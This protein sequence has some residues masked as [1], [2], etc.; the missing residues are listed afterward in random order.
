MSSQ[1]CLKLHLDSD[2][3]RVRVPVDKCQKVDDICNYVEMAWPALSEASYRL[4]Y[5]DDMD[6]ACILSQISLPD[7]LA[8]AEES[9]V[10][11]M[12][13]FVDI[14]DEED[15]VVVDDPLSRMVDELI[16]G[17]LI[18][19]YDVGQELVRVLQDAGQD[20]DKVTQELA[21]SRSKKSG[22]RTTTKK[23]APKSPSV[24]A[25]PKLQPQSSLKIEREVSD[26]NEAM[27]T[28]VD[29]LSDLGFVDSKKAARDLMNN[30]VSS[31]DDLNKVADNIKRRVED[32]QREDAYSKA[33]EC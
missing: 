16:D 2:I 19:S 15:V 22:S 26:E 20:L 23:N 3:L 27:D 10:P 24:A 8:L 18:P 6:D 9:R 30:L 32:Q 17:D 21:K 1:I 11:T 5:I 25:K 4:Y 12:N 14:D 13:I 31:T 29:L 28:M 7:A 33:D